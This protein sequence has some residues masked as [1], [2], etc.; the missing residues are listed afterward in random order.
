[1]GSKRVDKKKHEVVSDGQALIL[2]ADSHLKTIK[3]KQVK[4]RLFERG[5]PG[6]QDDSFDSLLD[7]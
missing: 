7:H 1:M 3:Q 2:Y 4:N 6:D 5:R